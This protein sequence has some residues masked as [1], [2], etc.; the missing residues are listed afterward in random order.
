MG[1]DGGGAPPPPRHMPA[2]DVASLV[3]AQHL[4]GIPGCRRSGEA[5]GGSEVQAGRE[6]EGC[7][8]PVRLSS[9]PPVI[10]RAALVSPQGL[11]DIDKAHDRKPAADADPEVKETGSSSSDD[12]SKHTLEGWEHSDTLTP[13]RTVGQSAELAPILPGPVWPSTPGLPLDARRAPRV[14]AK[15]APSATSADAPPSNSPLGDR[16]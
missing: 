5:G 3:A 7:R 12:R 16:V 2:I 1:A 13:R 11:I 14:A 6:D 15:G 4:V 10:A 8:G 9:N